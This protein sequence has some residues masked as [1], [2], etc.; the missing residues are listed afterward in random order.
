MKREKIE[1]IL[2]IILIAVFVGSLVWMLFIE[3]KM[4]DQTDNN[5]NTADIVYTEEYK[6]SVRENVIYELYG[7]REAYATEK[8]GSRADYVD[9]EASKNGELVVDEERMQQVYD[10]KL[11]EFDSMID[12]D[13]VDEIVNKRLEQLVDAGVYNT[14]AEDN[15]VSSRDVMYWKNGGKYFALVVEAVMILYVVFRIIRRKR[16]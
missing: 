12:N 16:M 15:K 10:S 4:L 6:Q 5:Q 14:L 7:S 3:P 11:A 9:K 13:K 2:L 1:Y 8:T